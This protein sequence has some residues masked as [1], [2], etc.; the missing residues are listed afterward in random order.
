M[1][2]E[3]FGGKITTPMI[4]KRED[5]DW[6]YVKEFTMTIEPG[7]STLPLRSYKSVIP[8]VTSDPEIYHVKYGGAVARSTHTVGDH[9][10]DVVHSGEYYYRKMACSLGVPPVPASYLTVPQ[11]VDLIYICA[12]Q[13]TIHLY[14]NTCKPQ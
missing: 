2:A 3:E 1:R 13:V 5:R 10:H 4:L 8:F 6:G 14:Q 11:Y 7:V 9:S 12:R